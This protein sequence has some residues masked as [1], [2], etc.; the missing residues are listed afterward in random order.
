M[1][2]DL[3]FDAQPEQ[4]LPPELFEQ[5]KARGQ[6]TASRILQELSRLADEGD[7]K[8]R[9]MLTRLGAMAVKLKE[10]PGAELL[11][12]N[13]IR[14]RQVN[15]RYTVLE[16]HLLAL[17]WLMT[18]ARFIPM[19]KGAEPV[20]EQPT[21]AASV[22]PEKQGMGQ[23][24]KVEPGKL[25]IA[26]R[27]GSPLPAA[28]LQ[29]LPPERRTPAEVLFHLNMLA[30]QGELEAQRAMRQVNELAA[31]CRPLPPVLCREQDG[32]LV[33]VDQE[34]SCLA[35]V[36]AGREDV[37]CSMI[38]EE[39]EEVPKAI[40]PPAPTAPAPQPPPAPA[41]E[42]QEL[43]A[44]IARFAAARSG[45]TGLA[46]AHRIAS[47]LG[48]I[49]AAMPDG[50][51]QQKLGSEKTGRPPSERQ[52][53]KAAKIY[54]CQK[55]NISPRYCNRLLRLLTLPT[56]VQ[57]VAQ[58]LTERQLHPIL[59]LQDEALQLAVVE[60]ILHQE[61]E[62]SAARPWKYP[63][64]AVDRLV[65]LVLAGT[66]VKQALSLAL[67]RKPR[68]RSEDMVREM[69]R[70]SALVRASLG[71]TGDVSPEEFLEAYKE[72]ELALGA[73]LRELEQKKR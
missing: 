34:L 55:L 13:R 33:V 61:K 41:G 47:L 5:L 16:G 4:I 45:L 40:K 43:E 32:V 62:R 6:A 46:Q 64:T 10:D 48:K 22:R 12:E 68:K 70:L 15:W 72:L 7:E 2:Q 23:V 24:I 27:D 30:L 28:L 29:A 67:E 17:A 26:A 60:G 58:S 56:S 59:K 57:K 42:W 11:P 63:S 35:A 52:R 8:A 21:E 65:K 19:T 44:E 49:A 36:A 9:Q 37:L 69:R 38:G 1:G 3:Y 54:L 25:R 31:K 53:L 39:P 71:K 73:K 51:I 14:Y 50:L 18:G 20:W 66:P